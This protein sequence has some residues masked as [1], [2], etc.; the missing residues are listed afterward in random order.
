MVA[1][2]R[3]D[4]GDIGE[5]HALAVVQTEVNQ[6]TQSV[7]GLLGQSHDSLSCSRRLKLKGIVKVCLQEIKI[8]ITGF[9]R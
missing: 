3:K 9:N 6:H 4:L 2:Y 5:S 7:I 1:R 8:R